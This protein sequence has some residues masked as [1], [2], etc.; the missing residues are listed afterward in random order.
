MERLLR[1]WKM[2]CL[3][4]AALCA[5]AVLAF[6]GLSKGASAHGNMFRLT[7]A[8][9]I[10]V[11]PDLMYFSGYQPGASRKKFCEDVPTTGQTFFVLDF[12]EPEMREMS[13]DF[14][15]MRLGANNDQSDA[16][17]VAYLPAKRY[18][19]GTIDLEHVFAEPGNFI[20]IV[21]A[22][23]THGELWVSQFPFSVG[24]LYSS[25]APYYLLAVA[26]VVALLLLLLGGGEKAEAGRP[27]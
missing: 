6:L 14:R 5:L 8:C 19:N 9:I 27:D 2:F 20:G 12:A 4:Y 10:K 26:A 16:A 11:G 17:T 22:A 7:N 23:G 3:R 1:T 13:V 25:K 21:T 24:R 18:P 15:I